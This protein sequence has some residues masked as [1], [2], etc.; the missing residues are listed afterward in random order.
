MESLRKEN[1]ESTQKPK[2]FKKDDV[3]YLKKIKIN[4][5]KTSVIDQDHVLYGKLISDVQIGGSVKLSNGSQTSNIKNIYEKGGK[6]FLET[7]TSIYEI[8]PNEISDLNIKNELGSINL[9]EGAKVAELKGE[10]LDK[11]F[12][13]PNKLFEFY[14]NKEALKGVLIEVNGGELFRGGGPMQG[15]FFVV[16]KVGNIH[17]PFYKSSA[18]TSGKN[19]GEWYPFFGAI[20]GWIVKGS[21]NKENGDMYYH[22]EIS[23][24][25]EILNKNLKFPESYISPRGVF[26]SGGGDDFET[27]S[28]WLSLGDYIKYQNGHF[29]ERDSNEKINHTEMVTGYKPEKVYDGKDGSSHKW[30]SDVVGSIKQKSA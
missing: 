28:V 13:S 3:V 24:V 26:G 7:Q 10:S 21:V 15:R 20:P 25:Q 22:D 14:I 8:Y 2:T 11:K 17:L 1:K 6:T 16:C 19:K 9:P 29:I 4:E 27:K 30:I 12:Q 23:K 18:G 5:G